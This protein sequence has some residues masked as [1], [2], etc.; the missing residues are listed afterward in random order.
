[1][2][3][4]GVLLARVGL[5]RDRERRVEAESI[6]QHAIEFPDLVAIAVEEG[7]EASLGAGGSFDPSA[8][9][10]REAMLQFMEIFQEVL[11][12]QASPFAYGG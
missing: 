7:Q 3:Y 1:M 2:E 6:R 12:P 4:A 11:C 10:A 9:Q 8:A 5:P